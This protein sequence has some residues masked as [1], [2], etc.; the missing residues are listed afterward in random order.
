LESALPK[1]PKQPKTSISAWKLIKL[2][3][4]EA[5]KAAELQGK[6]Q[7]VDCLNYNRNMPISSNEGMSIMIL[8]MEYL[9]A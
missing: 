7:N 6:E 4:D 5:M 9:T 3:T 2:T 8:L 1:F